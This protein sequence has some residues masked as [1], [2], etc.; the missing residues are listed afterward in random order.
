MRDHNFFDGYARSKKMLPVKA[1]ETRHGTILL[2]DSDDIIVEGGRMFYRTG[3][4]IL[5]GG[6]E[7]ANHADYEINEGLSKEQRLKE[8]E[9]NAE[10]YLS[11]FDENGFFDDDRKHDFS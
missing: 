6:A 11:K 3:W 2:A 7:F 5:R 4:A 8:A 10:W 1:V 9:L